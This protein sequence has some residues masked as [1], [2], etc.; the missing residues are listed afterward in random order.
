[1][2]LQTM[3]ASNCEQKTKYCKK[4]NQISKI[5]TVEA[6]F[7]YNSSA[8]SDII[9]GICNVKTLCPTFSN[10]FCQQLIWYDL[11]RKWNT[12]EL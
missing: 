9:P 10:L 1:M 6:I 3:P 2:K 4:K 7:N 8:D 5:K 12:I 11:T